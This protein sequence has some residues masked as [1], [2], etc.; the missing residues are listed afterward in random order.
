MSKKKCNKKNKKQTEIDNNELLV[1]KLN[2]ELS[3]KK[4]IDRHIDAALM[5]SEKMYIAEKHMAASKQMEEDRKLGLFGDYP[6]IN[7]ALHR[8]YNSLLKIENLRNN[9]VIPDDFIVLSKNNKKE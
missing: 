2:S 4:E 6:E 3:H 5:D 1:S 8:N 9:E 7:S